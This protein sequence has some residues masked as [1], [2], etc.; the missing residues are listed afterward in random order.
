MMW[1][2]FVLQNCQ[3]LQKSATQHCKYF[4]RFLQYMRG[5][6]LITSI[7]LIVG[8]VSHC[9]C[10]LGDTSRR[11]LLGGRI[12]MNED[13]FQHAL[14]LL[15][16][17]NHI[18]WENEGVPKKDTGK[19]VTSFWNRGG[20][21]TCDVSRKNGSPMMA[22]LRLGLFDV[23]LGELEYLLSVLFIRA[24]SEVGMSTYWMCTL[25]TMLFHLQ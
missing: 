8:I 7:F 9:F 21:K 10:Q 6:S 19:V 22:E 25:Y 13:N 2:F 1:V 11:S 16:P 20:Q 4:K 12:W 23:G 15:L 17:W 14:Y 3:F 24:A 5:T 18:F